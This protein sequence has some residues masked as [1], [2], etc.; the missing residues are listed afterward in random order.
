MAQPDNPLSANGAG[1]PIDD[2][3]RAGR[4]NAA[5]RRLKKVCAV[6]A[7]KG[8]KCLGDKYTRADVK[9]EFQ[10]AK[11]HLWMAEPG[12]VVKAGS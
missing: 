1:S 8:G 12:K 6:A 9:L 7:S 11:G 5:A 4:L 10:C 2:L 3:I